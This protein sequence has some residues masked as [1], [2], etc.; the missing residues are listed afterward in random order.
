MR[1]LNLPLLSAVLLAGY[2]LMGCEMSSPSRISVAPIT[3]EQGKNAQTF[4]VGEFDQ[5]NAEQVARHYARY[6]EGPI[7]VILLYG[8]DG[9]GYRAEQEARRLVRLLHQAKLD[10]VKVDTLPVHD[11]LQA[12]KV[13]IDYKTLAAKPPADCSL[14][15]AEDRA[16]IHGEDAGLFS[17]Y[18]FGCGIDSYT[19]QQV[20]RPRD[21]LGDDQTDPAHAERVVNRMKDFRA[22][23]DLPKLEGDNASQLKTQ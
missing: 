18:R 5:Y 7:D 19:A 13:M 12:G 10:D 9:S 3:V 15:P 6:G 23:K 2:G 17:D 20:A 22:G 16:A 4:L 11:P 1:V 14:H 8:A 21:L